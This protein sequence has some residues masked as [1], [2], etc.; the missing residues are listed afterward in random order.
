MEKIGKIKIG[1]FYF[2]KLC[3]TSFEKIVAKSPTIANN[4]RFLRRWIDHKSALKVVTSQY[5]GLAYNTSA[6]WMT[7]GIPGNSWKN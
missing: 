5:F 1:K 6:V 3:S 2:G 4:V 7:P